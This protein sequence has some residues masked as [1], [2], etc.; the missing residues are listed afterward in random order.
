MTSLLGRN[1]H[2]HTSVLLGFR[3]HQTLYSLHFDE[4]KKC[5]NIQRLL[6]TKMS[7]SHDSVPQ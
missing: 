2:S 7:M 3:T 6:R 1:K 5:I 4:K